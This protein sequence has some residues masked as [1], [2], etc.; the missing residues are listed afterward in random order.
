MSEQELLGLRKA[1]MSQPAQ[2]RTE[3]VVVQRLLNR[4][5]AFTGRTIDDVINDPIAQRQVA[6]YFKLHR[7]VE[8]ECEISELERQ[9]NAIA[10]RRR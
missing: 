7:W 2:Q 10:Q 5:L 6:G 4:V 8:R 1:A 9:W 3:H